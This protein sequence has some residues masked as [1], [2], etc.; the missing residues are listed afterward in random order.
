MENQIITVAP[1]AS[2]HNVVNTAKRFLAGGLSCCIVSAILNPMDNI[3]VRLQI[4]NSTASAASTAAKEYLGTSH[5]F[6]KIATEEGAHVL[7]TRGLAASM[8]RELSYSSIRMGAYDPIK[9]VLAGDTKGDIGLVKKILSGA[10]SGAIGASLANPFDLIKIRQQGE[11]RLLPG[12]QPRYRNLAR[13]FVDIYKN[14]GFQG[15]Y[16]GVGPTTVRASVLTAAQLSSYDHSKYLL[17]KS[18][19]FADSFSTHLTCSLI[20]GLV[21]ALVSSPVDVIKTRYMNDKVGSGGQGAQYRSAMDCLIK[22]VRYE[23]LR[24]LYSGF[25]PNYLRLGPHFV[26]SLPLLEQLRRLFGIT[27]V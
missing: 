27:S 11:G 21:T 7:W 17:L 18:K 9:H 23:G 22:T 13:A 15:L 24:A 12:Q 8:C 1:V 16:K 25:L 19:H 10:V 5:A 6:M 26:L 4:Q 14:E 2:D 3:K 20:S